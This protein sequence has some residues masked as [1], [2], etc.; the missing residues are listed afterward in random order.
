MRAGR[1]AGRVRRWWV[2]CNS[3]SACALPMP[4]GSPAASRVRCFDSKHRR[5]RWLRVAPAWRTTD[6]L[7]WCYAIALDARWHMA[8]RACLGGWG[9]LPD[10]DARRSRLC[11]VQYASSISYVA[12]GGPVAMQDRSCVVPLIRAHL[13]TE[14]RDTLGAKARSGPLDED[15]DEYLQQELRAFA[16]LRPIRPA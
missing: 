3:I 9:V 6:E 1:R 11:R 7:A 13:R 4:G 12:A 5:G 8:Q 10:T 15:F 2:R 16:T 14:I